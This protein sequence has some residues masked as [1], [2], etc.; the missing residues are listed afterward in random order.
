MSEAPAERS[1]NAVPCAER[2]PHSSMAGTADPVD[3][4][5][6]L[7]APGPWP[8]QALRDGPLATGE[9]GWLEKTLVALSAA[10]I[11]S[12]AQLIK[13]PRAAGDPRR[14]LLLVRHGCGLRLTGEGALPLIPTD[15]VLAVAEHLGA[16]ALALDEATRQIDAAVET[17]RA[18]HYFV[19]TNGRRDQ[20][21]SRLGMPL[22]R[23]LRAR[24][25]DRVWQLSHIGGHRFAGNV[26]TLPD[27]LL[28][29]RL[30]ADCCEAFS[31]VVESGQPAFPWLRGRT[32][33]TPLVQAAEAL[34]AR[35]GLKLLHVAGDEA[36]ARV[37]FAG[38]DQDY[39]LR[40]RRAPQPLSVLAGCDKT[41][42][43][44]YYPFERLE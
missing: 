14:S 18:P 34:I 17:L 7:E 11:R 4:W 42:L 12:R 40:L 41:S 27:G 25:G 28:Y 30:S 35:P 38:A 29:G 37:R 9:R 6:L 24:F 2:D 5:L 8:A 16:G 23:A 20:C 21:C 15:R 44:D 26:L 19:C 1:L 43:K 13:Q 39:Q 3:L 36:D 22:Y 33:Y 32:A 31:A 10:G